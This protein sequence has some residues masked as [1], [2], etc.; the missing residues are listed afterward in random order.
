M[1]HLRQLKL[2]ELE[3][4]NYSPNIMRSY[5]HAVEEFAGTFAIRLNSTHPLANGQTYCGGGASEQST[6]FLGNDGLPEYQG[7]LPT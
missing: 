5:L 7:D 4:R 2:D 3:R 1:S 6:L